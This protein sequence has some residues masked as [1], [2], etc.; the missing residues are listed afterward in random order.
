MCA[1]AFGCASHFSLPALFCFLH[2]LQFIRLG[3]LKHVQHH[4]RITTPGALIQAAC[5]SLLTVVVGQADLATKAT[6]S[7]DEPGLLHLVLSQIRQLR[8]VRSWLMRAVWSF[9]SPVVISLNSAIAAGISFVG[10]ST[11]QYAHRTPS[12][13]AVVHVTRCVRCP[14]LVA[15]L[16][17]VGFAPGASCCVTSGSSVRVCF[18]VRLPLFAQSAP[19][20]ALRVSRAEAVSWL[21]CAVAF[22]HQRCARHYVHVMQGA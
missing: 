17:A 7:A 20:F 13:A 6:I 2:G 3:C 4:L 9:K 19:W 22:M 1:E 8:Q 11:V 14:A 15:Q 16:N 10:C 18:S 5:L 12:D 21:T